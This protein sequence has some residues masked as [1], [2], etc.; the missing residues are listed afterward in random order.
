M[1]SCALIGPAV[2]GEPPRGRRPDP[3][4]RPGH[5]RHLLGHHPITSLTRPSTVTRIVAADAPADSRHDQ[6]NAQGET[7]QGTHGQ[8]VRLPPL[9]GGMAPGPDPPS[10]PV[11]VDAPGRPRRAG[12][13]RRRGRATRGPRGDRP[14]RSP[15]A[16]PGRATAHGLPARRRTRGCRRPSCSAASATSPTDRAGTLVRPRRPSRP[17]RGPARAEHRALP[18]GHRTTVRKPTPSSPSLADDRA[19]ALT[20]SASAEAP[21]APPRSPRHPHHNPLPRKHNR[22]RISD[23]PPRPASASAETQSTPGTRARGRRRRGPLLRRHS[24]PARLASGSV[25]P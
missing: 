3:P 6:Q 9:A 21:E 24:S 8:Y 19:D 12:R 17:A 15:A 14:D 13:E 25:S 22:P 1:A 5:Q 4:R 18:A 2:P 23:V 20:T 16:R 11:G 10:A 7:R